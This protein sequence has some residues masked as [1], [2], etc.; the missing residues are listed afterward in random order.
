MAQALIRSDFH[1]DPEFCMIN[2]ECAKK[3]IK[4]SEKLLLPVFGHINSKGNGSLEIANL[5]LRAFDAHDDAAVF[6]NYLL[7]I[8]FYDIN[9]DGYKDLL[10]RGTN[11]VTSDY[12]DDVELGRLYTC[13]VG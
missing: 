9:K 5:S 7:N 11:I 2:E 4:I 12:R 13:G 8:Y 10:A 1:Y 6:K 3:N